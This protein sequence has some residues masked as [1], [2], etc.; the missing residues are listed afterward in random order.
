MQRCSARPR[1]DGDGKERDDERLAHG[2]PVSLATNASPSG[3][4]CPK[5]A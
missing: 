2:E 3:W 1:E 5:E 4:S